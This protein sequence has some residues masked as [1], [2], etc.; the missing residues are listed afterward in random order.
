M[1]ISQRVHNRHEKETKHHNLVLFK[2]YSIIVCITAFII[3]L[4]LYLVKSDVHIYCGGDV[5][6][7]CEPCPEFGTCT[8]Y[9]CICD[10]TYKFINGKCQR[11][12]LLLSKVE[13]IQSIIIN[14]LQHL[15]GTKLY[16]K[17][18]NRETTELKLSETEFNHTIEENNVE[19]LVQYD[20]LYSELKE[21]LSK[22]I[23]NNTM[24]FKDETKDINNSIP[25]GEQEN[26]ESHESSAYIKENDKRKEINSPLFFMAPKEEAVMTY[27]QQIT[28]FIYKNRYILMKMITTITAVT[29]AF[30]KIYQFFFDKQLIRDVV[31]ETLNL[32]YDA[33]LTDP[34]ATVNLDIIKQQLT[35]KIHSHSGVHYIWNK[36]LKLLLNSNCL[37]I[38]NH[39]TNHGTI[40]YLATFDA[41][42]YQHKKTRFN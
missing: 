6:N 8:S 35:P 13:I 32:L 37:I 42:S 3:F 14:K 29:T 34:E 15:A 40:E 4:I 36:A 31:N 28:L 22:Y 9:K 30:I 12:P 24:S 19:N 16:Y 2:N 25:T 5:R 23:N 39:K 18:L 33:S 21:L 38:Y 27:T 17:E 11:D 26:K 1:S 7:Y 41:P 20:V 10:N